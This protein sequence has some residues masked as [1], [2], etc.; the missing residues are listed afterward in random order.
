MFNKL[1]IKI[2]KKVGYV[3]DLETRVEQR[4]AVET[5]LRE[6]KEPISVESEIHG[7]CSN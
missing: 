4:K 1:L 3:K 7:K 6:G 2:V 5:R